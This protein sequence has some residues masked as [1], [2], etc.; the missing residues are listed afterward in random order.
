MI[1]SIYP[2]SESKNS[3]IWIITRLAGADTYTA[4]MSPE[5]HSKMRDIIR[6]HFLPLQLKNRKKTEKKMK[7][8]SL[9]S[10]CSNKRNKIAVLQ[11]QKGEENE[12]EQK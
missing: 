12:R 5:E 1:L 7:L 4:V 2:S 10:V 6:R 9:S 8:F 3:K 11:K